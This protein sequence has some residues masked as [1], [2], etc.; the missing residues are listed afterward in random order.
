MT[1]NVR[2][3][4]RFACTRWTLHDDTI[5]DFQQLDN[6]DLLVVEGFREIEVT[7]QLA[8]RAVL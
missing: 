6:V 3:G 7:H 8:A 2:D 5:G 4:V 1:D